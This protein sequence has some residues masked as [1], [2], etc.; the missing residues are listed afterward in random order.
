[1]FNKLK[2]LFNPKPEVDW[3]VSPV[4]PDVPEVAVSKDRPRRGPAAPKKVKETTLTDKEK[5][6]AAGEPY[7]SIVK[8]DVDPDNINNGSVELDFNEKFVVNLIKA[9]YKIKADDTDAEMVDRWFTQICKGIVLEMYDQQ[10]ADPDKRDLQPLTK[11]DERVVNRKVLGDG[12]S[13][14]S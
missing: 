4:I 12:R 10:Q 1:M 5:A 8:I 6:T 2:N 3:K 11:V 13:E 14:I 7:V 9:G